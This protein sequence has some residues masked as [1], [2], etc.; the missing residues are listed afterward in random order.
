MTG[1][2]FSGPQETGNA[3]GSLHIFCTFK[4]VYLAINKHTYL[5]SNACFY[6]ILAYACFKKINALVNL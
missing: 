2:R 5:M 6:C 3:L 1:H 4:F